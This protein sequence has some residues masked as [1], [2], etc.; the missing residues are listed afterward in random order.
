MVMKKETTWREGDRAVF[1]ICSLC[2]LIDDAVDFFS[3]V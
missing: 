2:F 3:H 1:P